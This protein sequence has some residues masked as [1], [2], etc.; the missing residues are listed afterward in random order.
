MQV[1]KGQLL[2]L[3]F[4]FFKNRIFE[5]KVCWKVIKEKKKNLELILHFASQFCKWPVVIVLCCRRVKGTSI[6]RIWRKS[7]TSLTWSSVTQ[8]LMI[9]WITVMLIKTDW[10][11]SWNFPI[12][13][14]GKTNCQ[15]T[16]WSRK[17][18]QEVN[19]SVL[20]LKV[21]EVMTDLQKPHK[22][23]STKYFGIFL[24][25]SNTVLFQINVVICL[26]A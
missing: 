8:C 4:F 9:S 22:N 5:T 25:F 3:F 7:A 1:Q 17:F 13:L 21:S 6:S 2:L 18:S 20:A 16:G 11:A 19:L 10:S 12:F 24:V 14:I 23:S 15:S 26:W